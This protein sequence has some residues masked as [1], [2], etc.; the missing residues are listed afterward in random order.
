MASKRGRR[1]KPFQ[2]REPRV[3]Y[4]GRRRTS[5]PPF[6]WWAGN[7]FE[8]PAFV[9]NALRAATPTPMVEPPGTS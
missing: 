3:A 4:G 6:R 7:D 1:D 5:L 9:R 8:C 2:V